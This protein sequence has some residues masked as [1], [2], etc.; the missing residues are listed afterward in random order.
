M[1]SVRRVVP[2][3][4][5]RGVGGMFLLAAHIVFAINLLAMRPGAFT[6]AFEPPKKG[7]AS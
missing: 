5:W 2:Y 3:M 6:M 7:R 4:V 1:E